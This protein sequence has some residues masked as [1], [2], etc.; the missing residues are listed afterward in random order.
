MADNEKLQAELQVLRAENAQLK[1]ELQKLTATQ[2]EKSVFQTLNEYDISEHLKKKDKIIYLPWSKAWMI[3]KTLYPDSQV[4]VIE[5]AGFDSDDVVRYFTDGK[6]AWVKV[7]IT[8]KGHTE[9]ESLAIMDF[10]NKSIP[11]AN[12]TSADVEKSIKR[13]MVKCAA[14]HGL[15]LSLWTGEELSSAAREKK[16]NDLDGVK[17]D[18][19]I[20][21]SG[22]LEAGVPKEQIYKVIE[23]IAGTKN[24]NAIKDIPTAQKVAE[25][26]K[27]LEVK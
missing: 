25:Q 11:V 5:N 24:P 22:K 9:T 8:I 20:I 13:C 1:D 27:K 7:A 23:S 14:L 17:Q 19:L 21:V 6:T 16:E 26:I 2:S 15:G 12:I 18:I 3:L 10:R 4:E